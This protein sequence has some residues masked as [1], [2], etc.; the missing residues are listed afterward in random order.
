[1]SGLDRSQ[2]SSMTWPEIL[3]SIEDGCDAAILPVGATEQH[4]PHLGVGMD[5]VLAE[6]LCKEVAKQS[7]V[8]ALPVLNYSCSIGH[9]H[10]WPGTIALSPTTMIAVMCDICEWLYRAGIRRI[11]IVNCHVG[12]KNSI[13]CAVDTMRCRYD[14]L[15]LA[16]LHT[17]ELSTVLSAAFTTD[18]KDWH[19]NAGETSLMMAI[20][21]EMVREEL[22]KSADDP[23]RTEGCVFTHP[24]NH[25]SKNGVTGR[26]SEASE[27]GGTR[28]FEHLV[29]ALCT[30]IDAGLDEASPLSASYFKRIEKMDTE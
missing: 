28:L 8:P 23:D 30:R 16:P 19:A 22:C 2:W 27:F 21:P 9:S 15:L 24:V 5:F 25:T 7:G 6:K 29:A 10:R 13:G 11:F 3:Q 20:A 17:G 12:N 26:P 14:D 1:M 4:G 18:A